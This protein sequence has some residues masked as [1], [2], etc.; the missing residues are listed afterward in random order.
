MSE[1][2]LPKPSPEVYAT[3]IK[4]GGFSNPDLDFLNSYDWSS[5]LFEIN[6]KYGLQNCIGEQLL[7]PVFENF[8]MMS[9]HNLKIGGR[10]VA[11]FNNKWGIISLDGNSGIWIVEPEYDYIGYPNSITMFR[12]ADKF[13]VMNTDTKEWILPLI[14]DTIYCSSGFMFING[15][16][17]YKIAGKSGLILDSGEYT[18]AIYDEVDLAAEDYSKARIGDIWGYVAKDGQLVQDPDEAYFYEYID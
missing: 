18:E 9:N 2:Q 3:F 15:I 13:G 1:N 10:V 6:G 7:S 14:C 8:Q 17:V 5:V 4:N 12:K 11:E 16:G